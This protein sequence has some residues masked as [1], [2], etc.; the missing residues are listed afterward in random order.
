[1]QATR[2]A[3]P[4]SI[5]RSVAEDPQPPRPAPQPPQPPAPPTPVPQPPPQPDEPPVPTAL[6]DSARTVADRI[7]AHAAARRW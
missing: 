3:I 6:L 1:M 2:H 7:A 4:S 5:D